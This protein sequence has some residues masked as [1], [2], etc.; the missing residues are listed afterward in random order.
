MNIEKD[1]WHCPFCNAYVTPE[2]L[3]RDRFFEELLQRVDKH[4]VELE[5]TDSCDNYKATKIETP[6][7]EA[8]DKVESETTPKPGEQQNVISLLS[9]DE[10]EEGEISEP[11]DTLKRKRNDQPEN[12]GK[13]KQPKI[14]GESSKFTPMSTD[15]I[16]NN[17]Y[18][19][20]QRST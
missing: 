10:E 7:V 3:H 16:L 8:D 2:K 13:G 17:L 12:T 18:N 6:D 20:S 1:Y 19:S 11:A 14:V 9:D 4:V 5:F 15:E